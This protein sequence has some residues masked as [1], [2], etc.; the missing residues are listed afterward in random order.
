[1]AGRPRTIDRDHVLDAAEAVVAEVGAGGLTIDAVA[2]TAGITKG[3]VQYCFGSKDDLIAAMLRRWGA[4]FDATL[5]RLAGDDPGPDRRLAAY[6]Q[7]VRDA[8]EAE[9]SR[10]AVMLAAL[11]QARG[12]L[13]ET[14]AWYRRQVGAL[15]D[16]RTPEGRRRR[17][18]LLA[19]EGA[20]LLRGFG[21]LEIGEDEWRAI[22]EDIARLADGREDLA[23]GGSAP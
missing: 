5:Q 19:S 21:F 14:R 15:G 17:L 4:E 8:S 9:S 2:R 7:A 18:A 6:L 3:G 10:E 11:V 1:M 12:N 20:F 13:A 23:S 22:F 16:P